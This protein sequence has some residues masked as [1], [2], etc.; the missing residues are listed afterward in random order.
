MSKRILILVRHAHRS[1]RFGSQADNGLSEKGNKQAGGILR[2][3][4]SRF[5]GLSAADLELNSS[6]KLRCLQTVQPIAE[7][8]CVKLKKL[9]CL[10]EGGDLPSMVSEF[11]SRW[12]RGTA[13]VTVACSHGD[14]IPEF[15]KLVT[16]AEGILLD[17][18]AWAELDG[19][20]DGSLRLRWVIQ[21]WG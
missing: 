16:G 3:F 4:L 21:D 5:A 15:L 12:R 2:H 1:K 7:V 6:P 20:P 17:K 18:G 8:K 9:P 10:G 19:Q 11:L 14:W 13:L